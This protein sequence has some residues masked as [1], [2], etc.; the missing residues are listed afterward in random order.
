MKNYLQYCSKDKLDLLSKTYHYLLPYFIHHIDHLR[1]TIIHTDISNTNVI[2]HLNQQTNSYNICGI[3]DFGVIDYG[4][5]IFEL[6]IMMAYLLLSID[7]DHFRALGHL[8]L[9]Y[10]SVYPITKE[11]Y[12]GLY[13]LLVARLIQTLILCQFVST[14][15][16]DNPFVMHGYDKKWDR[17]NL[18]LSLSE[19]DVYAIWDPIVGLSTDND[20][21]NLLPAPIRK[22]FNS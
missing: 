14:I 16:P 5:T 2:V 12:K 11:E 21:Y 22:G 15:D 8:I 18:M 6:A 7:R 17:L 20:F 1:W 10:H 19:S 9:G 4:A 13:T 3:I